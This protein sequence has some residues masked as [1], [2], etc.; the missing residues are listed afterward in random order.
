MRLTIRPAPVARASPDNSDLPLLRR[1][2]RH[3]NAVEDWS[4]SSLKRGECVVAPSEG[5][6]FRFEFLLAR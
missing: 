1:G 6:P 3:R 5:L 2:V 4:M